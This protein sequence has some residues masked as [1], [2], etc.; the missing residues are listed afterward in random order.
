M[1]SVI[2]SIEKEFEVFI[3]KIQSADV[4][5]MGYSGVLINVKTSPTTFAEIQ[6]NTPQMIYGK[7]KSCQKIIGDDLFYKIMNESG[8][9]HGLGHK[10]YEQWRVLDKSKDAEKMYKLEEMSKNYYEKLRKVQ[11]GKKSG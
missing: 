1:D 7:S 11:L 8:L 10:Y 9:E 4:D 5:K 2:A 6:L 3:T